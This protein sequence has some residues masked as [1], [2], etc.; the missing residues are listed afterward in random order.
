MPNSKNG[1][2]LYKINF[3]FGAVTSHVVSNDESKNHLKAIIRFTFFG[4][5]Y[6]CE[7]FQPFMGNYKEDPIE[8]KTPVDLNGKIHY[9]DFRAS[10]ELYYREL[11]KRA[12]GQIPQ[13]CEL[14][15]TN[16]VIQIQM[17]DY[18]R[19]VGDPKSHGWQID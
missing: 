3:H 11:M 1:E 19:I 18:I 10:M 4:K 12:F 7:V 2:P 13:R 5:E 8:V 15:L 17:W 16:S 14:T 6:D 9:E